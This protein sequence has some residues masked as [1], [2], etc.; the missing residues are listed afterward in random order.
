M[1]TSVTLTL[2]ALA[3]NGMP[4]QA[5]VK[6]TAKTIDARVSMRTFMVRP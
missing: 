2:G 4:V 3:L 5:V 1:P 6:A